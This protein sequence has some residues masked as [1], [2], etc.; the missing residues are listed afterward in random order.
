MDPASR[1]C[2]LLD[3]PSHIEPDPANPRP[4]LL[5]P[6][7]FEGRIEFDEV[8]ARLPPNGHRPSRRP[9]WLALPTTPP[10]P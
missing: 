4:D 3:E 6:A 7:A 9:H 5:R 2:E 1:I 10:D 8:G